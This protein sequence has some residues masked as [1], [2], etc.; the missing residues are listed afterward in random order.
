LVLHF[1]VSGISVPVCGHSGFKLIALVGYRLNCY[2]LL[3]FFRIRANFNMLKAPARYDR[4][5]MVDRCRCMIKK[6]CFGMLKRTMTNPSYSGMGRNA[7]F[8]HCC[9]AAEYPAK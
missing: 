8:V 7:W 4:H 5:V 9:A 1:L 6:V 2:L 3:L